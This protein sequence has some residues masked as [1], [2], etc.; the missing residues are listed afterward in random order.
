MA[1]YAITI[2]S[3]SYLLCEKKNVM[4]FKY[5]AYSH[6]NAIERR[7]IGLPTMLRHFYELQRKYS[8]NVRMHRQ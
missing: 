6:N 5:A 7:E 4:K 1:G 3:Q 2:D 8:T